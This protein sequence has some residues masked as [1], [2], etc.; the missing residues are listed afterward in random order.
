M[1]PSEIK[2]AVT[3]GAGFLGSHIVDYL[4]GQG[5]QTVAIDDFSS[6]KME[7]IQ[8]HRGTDDFEVRRV[9]LREFGPTYEALQD[10]DVV[11][12]LAAKI[13]G[14]GYFHKIPADIIADNDL[15]NRNVFNASIKRNIRRMI[16]FSSS[17]VFERATSFPSREEDLVQIPPPISAY[18]FQKLSGEYYC[19]AYH[20]QYGL[21]YTILRPF[22]AVGPREFPGEE[23]GDAH[24]VPDLTRKIIDLHQFPLEI[25]G[26]G[27]QER[28][29]TNVKDLA[30]GCYLAIFSEQAA[31][32]DFNLGNPNAIAI[33]D[34]AKK[35]WT[36]AGEERPIKFKH[37]ESFSADVQRRIPSSEKAK[38]LLDWEPA[39]SLDQSLQEYINWYREVGTKR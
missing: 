25:F 2:A 29:F 5:V 15:I 6:G 24:V 13:G 16:Y 8:H 26:S 36:I 7:N 17:M 9:D 37:L 35:I 4:I 30:R 20:R 10:I 23:V 3:G 39:I 27:E 1:N 38:K 19:R 18:G 33:K 22:N 14:I 12:H 11:V 28:A 31:N 21:E 32:E 34:L